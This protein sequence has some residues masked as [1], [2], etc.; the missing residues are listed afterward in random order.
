[1]AFSPDGKWI[2]SAEDKTVRLWDVATGQQVHTFEGHGGLSA[3]RS[4]P[5]AG[6][7]P[8]ATWIAR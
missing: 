1:M 3:W 4:A 7:S 8:R 6:G 5:T 2:A